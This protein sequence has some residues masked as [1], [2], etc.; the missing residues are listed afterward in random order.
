M[1][2]DT[3]NFQRC[4]QLWMYALNM[5][6]H[7]LEPLSPLTQSSLLSFAELFSFMLSEGRNRLP[8]PSGTRRS[9][10]S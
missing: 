10:S 5:Q 9:G 3:G 4:I 1:Y 2:A 7:I 6:Q 8:A